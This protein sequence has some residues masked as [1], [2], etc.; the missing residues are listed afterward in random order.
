MI[1]SCKGA[2]TA[3][4]AAAATADAFVEEDIVAAFAAATIGTACGVGSGAENK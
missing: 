4:A 1:F 3:T 2:T